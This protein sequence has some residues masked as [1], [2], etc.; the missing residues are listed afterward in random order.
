MK[1]FTLTAAEARKL[2]GPTL[3]EKVEALLHSIENA[4]KKHLRLLKTGY[5]HAE[6][7][8]LWQQ[9]GYSQTADWLKAQKM[10]TDLGYKV[11][12][13]YEE[14]QLVEMYTLIEW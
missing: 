10:L 3:E 14:I 5:M 8:D 4:A 13:F 11:T 6:D 12:F 1:G 9:G 2:A 7:G